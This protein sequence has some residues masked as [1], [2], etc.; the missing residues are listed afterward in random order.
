VLKFIKVD[1]NA[2][3]V[4][5]L[6]GALGFLLANLVPGLAQGIGQVHDYAE[7]AL[8]LFFFV[9]GLELKH[10][11]TSG[12]FKKKSS[13][14][15]PALA[16]IFG[17]FIPAGLYYLVTM[18]DPVAVQGWAI[19]MAT[20]IT[21][22]VAVFSIFG[23][24]LPNGSKQFLLAFAIIDDLLAILVIALFLHSDV[25][26]AL[27]VTGSVVLGLVVP[28]KHVLRIQDA[29]QPWVYLIVL[30]VYAF[31]SLCFVLNASIIEVATGL[32]AVAVLLRVLGKSIGIT[33]GA[34]LGSLVAPSAIKLKDV[35]RISVLGGIGFTVAFFVND[36]VFKDNGTLHTQA[37][38]GSLLA[39]LI[40]VGLGAIALKVK[41]K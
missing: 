27:I 30:P 22:A 31:S 2:A 3:L 25:T 29:I 39:G 12:V 19:P 26:T 40:S 10:E 20:D 16:A 36:I 4:I 28:G 18:N 33:L 32:V 14:L 15:V 37:I 6:A 24:K 8:A 9:I 13:L 17:A 41:N 34:Y 35:F 1:R 23:S 38:V 21:F 11:L 7:F 5:L